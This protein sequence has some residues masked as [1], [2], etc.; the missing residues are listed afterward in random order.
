MFALTPYIIALPLAGF[1][2][3]GLFGYKLK[4][5]KLIGIIGSG[6]IGLSF[7][8][9]CVIFFSLL[10]LPPDERRLIVPL[11]TWITT[12]T[13]TVTS[14]DVAFALQVDQLSIL[15]TLIVTGVG[16]LIHVY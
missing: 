7:V 16:F 9:A 8:I 10:K 13:G 11:F 3:L 4:N 1:L 5:E 14:L 12:A 15:M 2:F 6:T